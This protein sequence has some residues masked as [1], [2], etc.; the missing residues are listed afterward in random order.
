[1]GKLLAKLEMLQYEQIFEEQA[2]DIPTLKL[3][4]DEVP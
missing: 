4:S 3:L 2:I 1:M